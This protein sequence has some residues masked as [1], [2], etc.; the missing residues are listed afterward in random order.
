M[1]TRALLFR[2]LRITVLVSAIVPPGAAEFAAQTQAAGKAL[3][4]RELEAFIRQGSSDSFVSQELLSRGLAVAVDRPLLERLAKLG[5]GPRTISLLEHLL[6]KVRLVIRTAPGAD[7][8]LDGV[9]VATV[10]DTGEIV[11]AVEPGNYQ[12]LIAKQHCT[13]LSR[14]IRLVL[15][16]PQRIEAPLAWKVGFLTLDAGLP[17][18]Q[19]AIA[20]V[21]QFPGRVERLPVPVG[22]QQVRVSAPFRVGFSTVVVVE[23]GKTHEVPVTLDVDSAALKPLGDEIQGACSKSNYLLAI[24]R[25]QIY[26]QHGGADP[27]V[28]R[29]LALGH[30]QA[31][32]FGTFPAVAAK[33]LAAGAELTFHVTHDHSAFTFRGAHGAEL[34]ISAASIRFTPIG[35]CSTGA[36]TVPIAH[37]RCTL[38]SAGDSTTL[39]LT[40]PNP[41]NPARSAELSFVDETPADLAAIMRLIDASRAPAPAP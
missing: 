33:A 32:Q 3:T 6:P 23:G 39:T 14:P 25:G 22:P 35:K 16:H 18:A 36:L 26:L 1:D 11:L 7:V 20:G 2:I 4:V 5:A 15:N 19:I 40:F 41:K 28:L 30:F 8:A 27:E 10:G 34:G 29:V 21:G 9:A 13:S 37:V 24:A 12:L 38:R 17:D 31:K